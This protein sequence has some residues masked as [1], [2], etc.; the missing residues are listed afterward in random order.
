MHYGDVFIDGRIAISPLPVSSG[1]RAKIKY[2]GLLATSG[3]T[4]LYMHCGYGSDWYHPMEIPMERVGEQVW[5]GPVEIRGG[6]VLNVC[7]RDS[8]Q[9]W[10][11]NHG[12]NWSLPI[13]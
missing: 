12:L 13:S 4:E 10:D 7:F 5:E 9:N 8:A 6:D 1:K 2:K 11:N 3:A